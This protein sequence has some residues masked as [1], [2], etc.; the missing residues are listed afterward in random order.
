V[1]TE[2]VLPKTDVAVQKPAETTPIQKPIDT[3]AKKPVINTPPPVAGFTFKPEAQHFA[4][5]LLTKV[6]PVFVNEAKNAFARFSK[7]K[8]HSIPLDVNFANFNSDVRLL[9]IGNFPNAQAATDYVDQAK[10]Q[11]RTDIIPWL[12]ADKYHFSIITSTN[13]EV[14]QANQD[15]ISYK[16]FID[17]HFPGKF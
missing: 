13:L 12:T 9:L 16:K 5:V 3:V 6:D 7:E 8:F 4:L 2:T 17:Q 10:R 1:K 11:A 14:L 15:L